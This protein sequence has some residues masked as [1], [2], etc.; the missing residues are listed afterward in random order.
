LRGAQLDLA[1]RADMLDRQV[2]AATARLLRQE[3]EIIWRLAKAIEFRDGATGEHISRVARVSMAIAREMA[4]SQETCRMVY[5]AAP[6]HDVGK[7]GITDAILNKPGRLTED[8][9]AEI[10]RHPQIGLDILDGSESLLLQ[11]AAEIAGGHHERWD[12]SGYPGGLAG[13]VIPLPARIVAVADVFD[14]LCSSRPYKPAWTLAQ[15]RRDIVLNSGSHFDPACVG[16]FVR[17]WDEITG[18]YD[19]F[20]QQTPQIEVAS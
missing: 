2:L 1:D 16:A 10:R 14:A 7:I 4:M 17:A 9:F 5:L 13:E 12:G 3:E 15:A 8:E 20:G 19:H 6:L 18:I 11:M